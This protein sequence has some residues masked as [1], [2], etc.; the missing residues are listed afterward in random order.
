[1][2]SLNSAERKIDRDTGFSE[3][4][5]LPPRSKP[6][7]I[8]GAWEIAVPEFTFSPRVPFVSEIQQKPAALIRAAELIKAHLKSVDRDK[9]AINLKLVRPWI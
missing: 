8:P 3:D 4:D 6:H 2:F 1:M 5:Q 7:D 9:T